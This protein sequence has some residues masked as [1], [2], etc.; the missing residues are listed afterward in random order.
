VN[1]TLG[2]KLEIISN[3]PGNY[4]AKLHFAFFDDEV[5]GSS[6]PSSG[7]NLHYAAIDLEFQE[8]WIG[9]VSINEETVQHPDVHLS[10]YPNPFNPTTTISFNLTTE[11]TKLTEIKIYN[12]KGQKIK[13]LISAQLSAGQHSVI[14]DG[15]DSNDKQ[16][17]S[18]IYFYKMKTSNF[19]QTKK[20]ILLK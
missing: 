16:V 4:H 6:S 10:N 18:G 15:K 9:P 17:G 3:E 11:N 8:Q 14:W 5:Y 12:I 13:T 19:Q 2:D 20:M 1:I 7:G